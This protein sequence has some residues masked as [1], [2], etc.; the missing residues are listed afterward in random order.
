MIWIFV[1]VGLVLTLLSLLFITR[2]KIKVHYHHQQADDIFYIKFRAWFGILRYTIAVPLESFPDDTT[3]K[4]SQENDHVETDKE[5]SMKNV[6][7]SFKDI[8]RHISGNKKSIMGFLNRVK[9]R[10]FDWHT[11]AGTGDAALTGTL[12]GGCLGIKGCIIGMLGTYLIF[13]KKPSYS[14]TPNFREAV[15]HTSLTC[16]FQ[17]RIGEAIW[18]AIKLL[19]YWNAEKMKF[20]PELYNESEKQSI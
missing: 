3:V 7:N 15:F 19:R 4:N 12:A 16:I 6:I 14:V 11:V 2:L 13:T 17:V 10:K 8:T 18:A 1:I 20:E 9:V 5:I